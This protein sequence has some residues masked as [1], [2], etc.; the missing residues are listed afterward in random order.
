MKTAATFNEVLESI[1]AF[2]EEETQTLLEIIEKRLIEGKRE[3]FAKDIKNARREFASGKTKR[4][5]V[6][7]LMEELG[8]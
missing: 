4:G 7:D 2:S 1:E 8:R 5:D 6:D 3:R